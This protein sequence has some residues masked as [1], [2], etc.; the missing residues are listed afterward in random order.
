[1]RHV[2]L[3]LLLLINTSVFCQSF[4]FS[5]GPTCK[6]KPGYSTDLKFIT[7]KNGHSHYFSGEYRD[8]NVE[9]LNLYSFDSNLQLTSETPFEFDFDK[10]YT[11]VKVYCVRSTDKTFLI[12]SATLK[13]KTFNISTDP[14]NH[15]YYLL[16]YEAKLVDEKLSLDFKQKIRVDS[17]VVE[18]AIS[19]DKSKIALLTYKSG[20][21][22]ELTVLD[23][24][25]VLVTS[26]SIS[27]D[28][29][30]NNWIF[31]RRMK[32]FVNN[33]GTVAIIFEK[34]N[35]DVTLKVYKAD[36]YRRKVIPAWLLFSNLLLIIAISAQVF[37][38]VRINRESSPPC[39]Y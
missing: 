12:F 31:S 17:E 38:L 37:Q 36:T 3:L 1:M 16:F 21:P 13:D 27:T 33:D 35:T 28:G 24:N 6:S 29:M 26:K 15:E 32:H 19:R 34:K 11:D 5:C 4:N 39:Y 8:G 22:S 30:V 2:F 25:L 23:D 14:K 10:G 9:S 18:I 7:S 20:F